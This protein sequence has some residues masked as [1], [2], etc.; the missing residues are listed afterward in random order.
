MLWRLLHDWVAGRFFLENQGKVSVYIS[1]TH[2]ITTDT[3]FPEAFSVRNHQTIWN[4]KD[5][6]LSMLWTKMVLL[7]LSYWRIETTKTEILSSCDFWQQSL[8]PTN[9][10]VL[11]HNF[12]NKSILRK[13]HQRVIRKSRKGKV[14]AKYMHI[15]V[16]QNRYQSPV[17]S[18][19]IKLVLKSSLKG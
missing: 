17:L 18:T 1:D 10:L 8:C 13:K 15:H 19:K 5:I 2:Y 11:K 12:L 14:V 3:C 16:S 4:V 7:V 6:F 9:I